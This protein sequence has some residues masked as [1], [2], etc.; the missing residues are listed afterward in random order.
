[1]HAHYKVC[2]FVSFV[3]VHRVV[4]NAIKIIH[5][6]RFICYATWP[7]LDFESVKILS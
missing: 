3:Y 5:K 4:S 6:Y 7:L 1:M 2:S